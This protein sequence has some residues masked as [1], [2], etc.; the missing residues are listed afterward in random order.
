MTKKIYND[1]NKVKKEIKKLLG[2]Y[3]KSK[4]LQEYFTSKFEAFVYGNLILSFFKN[5]KKENI[6]EL[7]LKKGQIEKI[8]KKY[9]NPIKESRFAISLKHSKVSKKYYGEFKSRVKKDFLGYEQIFIKIE[10]MIDI[11]KLEDFFVQTK[12][13][14]L[15]YGKPENDSNSFLA[16]KTVE[17][18]LQKNKKFPDNND[19]NKLMRVI[20]NDGIPKFSKEVKKNLNKTSKEMLEY[21]R[22]YQKGF[23]K[24]LYARWKI[25]IDLLECLIKISLESGEKQKHKLATITDKTNNYRIKALIK[26][27]ARAI[28]ISNEILVLLKAGYADGANARWRSLHELAVISLFLSR[29]S[30]EV[31]KRYLEHEI[32]KKYKQTDDYRKYYKR[33]GCAP[34]ERKEFNAIKRERERLCKKYCSDHFQDDYGWIPKNILSNRNFRTL[35]QHVK[36]DW[37]HPFYSLS[38]DSVHG[39]SKGFYRLS[40]MDEWQD[41][42]LLVG[43]SNYGL[44]DPI[45]NTAISLLHTNVSLLRIQPSFENII[46]IQV[47]NSYVQDIGPEAVRVQKQIEKDEKKR[48]SYL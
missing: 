33:L 10:E 45:Q 32:I 39:G 35:E 20:I 29:N 18:Y 1:L 22:N 14:F 36:L 47:I 13:E 28:H 41:R 37:L 27:H 30:N 6:V 40:L 25:P 17:L 43:A 19:L 42:I 15:A 34:I 11:K 16:T 38:C 3:S 2:T 9:K 23:E 7:N 5:L 48:V 4:A 44:A 8:R 46:V 26:I 12:K 31:S 24:R 21:Q